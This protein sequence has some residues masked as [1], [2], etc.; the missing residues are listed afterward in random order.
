MPPGGPDPA[1]AERALAL[2]DI[3]SVSG[4]EAAVHDYVR[5]A[6]PLPLAFSDGE[7]LLYAKRTGKLKR[8]G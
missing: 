8:N 6:V 3:P 5:D 4:D 2:V 1:L 7:T